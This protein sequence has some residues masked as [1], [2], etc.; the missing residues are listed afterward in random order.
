M[1]NINTDNK[2]GAF[3]ILNG[4]HYIFYLQYVTVN[5]DDTTIDINSIS[6]QYL[7]GKTES[8]LINWDLL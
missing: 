7:L 8:G 4:R 2:R 3:Q 1:Y 6:C 5:Y